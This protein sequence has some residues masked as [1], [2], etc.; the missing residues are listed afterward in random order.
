MFPT[1]AC[2][3]T[4]MGCAACSGCVCDQDPHRPPNRQCIS[5]DLCHLFSLWVQACGNK[6]HVTVAVERIAPGV[7]CLHRVPL[8]LAPIHVLH[9]LHS[10]PLSTHIVGRCS[11]SSC[12]GWATTTSLAHLQKC[13]HLHKIP[14]HSLS[15]S[16]S[17]FCHWNTS[18]S[19]GLD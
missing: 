18:S 7:G 12:C 13:T 3:H 1:T 15:W 9:S 11:A 16:E 4:K 2:S 8:L 10:P 14:D 5:S 19:R 17:V 6:G